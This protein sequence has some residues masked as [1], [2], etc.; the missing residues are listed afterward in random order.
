MRVAVLQPT[1]L[2]WMGYFGM[3]DLADIF[4]FYDDVQFSA[5]SWQQRN[6]I[7]SASGQSIWLSVNVIRDFGQAINKVQTKESNW[8]KKHWMSIFQSYAKAPHF[9]QYQNDLENIYSREWKLLC[10]LNIFIIRKFS[11]L[12]GVRIPQFK[13][14]SDLSNTPGRKTDRLL[15]V[16]EQL[17][18]D[19]YIAN[20][21]SKD[22]L[23]IDKFKEQGVKVYWFEFLHPTY[24]QIRGEF[25][26]Y[27]S[28]L[29]LLCNA[30]QDAV[31]YIREGS[32]DALRLDA[33]Y[34]T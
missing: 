7:K 28:A 3:I 25:I 23:E 1:Y 27:M 4:V 13:R 17:E 16:L 19:T 6:R 10:D 29:D 14:S 22:Y 24:P 21:G 32:K 5:Q 30:G 26:P 9:K 20:P 33:K 11:E 12:F 8:K 15:Q 2:P 34:T 31:N 18:A